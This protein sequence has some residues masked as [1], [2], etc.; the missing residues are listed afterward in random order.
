ML[1]NLLRWLDA[2]PTHYWLV[3]WSAFTLVAA[4]SLIAFSF[5]RERAWWQNPVLFSVAM[6][7]VLLAFRWPML[8]DNRQYPDPDESQFIAGALT[9]RQDPVFWRS[10]DGTTHGPLVQWPLLVASLVRGSLDFTTARTVSTLLIWIELVSAWLIFRHLYT[11]SLAGLL[12]LPLLAVHA[13][14]QAWS[15]VAYCSEH[16]P[17]ALLATACWLLLTG[18]RQSGTG[19]PNFVRLF[20]AGVL[21]GAV[22]FAKL[23]SAPIA[24]GALVAGIWLVSFND[25]PKWWAAL[26][27]LV[28]GTVTIPVIIIGMVLIFGAWPDFFRSYVLDNIR[29]VGRSNFPPDRSFTLLDTPRMLIELGTST[30]GFN[31]FFLGMVGLGAFGLLTFRWFSSWHRRCVVFATAIL[32]LAIFAAMVPGRPYLHYLQLLLFPT[33][34]FGGVVAGAVLRDVI[35]ANITRPVLAR[36]L[37]SV[38]LAA[39]LVCVLLPQVWWRA[40]EAQPFIGRF[41]ATKGALALSEVS[42]EILRHAKPGERLGMWGWM[43]VFWAETGLIQATRDGNDARQIESHAERDYYRARFLRDLVR[44]QPPVFIDAVGPGNFVYEDRAQ[45]AHETF[46]EL[47]DH[48]AGNY[49]LVRDVEGSRVYVRNDRL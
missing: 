21:L 32:F 36:V 27:A 39:F 34:L 25:R 28:S 18:L 16:V 37:R 13:F 31:S 1:F 44:S 26:R 22:P 17:D 48:I 12:V 45:D 46:P 11:A 40:H 42:Q 29:Y 49:H 4:L 33:G 23:Q 6:L 15:F 9:L 43:P 7:G 14:T 20:S 24:A 10:V 41:S 3:A 35:S 8:F 47:R 30:G 2:S 5:D 19:P 38:A